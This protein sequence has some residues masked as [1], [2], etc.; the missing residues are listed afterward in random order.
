MKSYQYLI[1]GGGLAGG[2]AIDGIRK[3]DPEGTIA[4]VAR[5]PHAPYQRPP[6][7]KGYLTGGEGLDQVY[8][9]GSEYY[10]QNHVD[11]LTGT[12]A[13]HIDRAA[14]TVRLGNGEALGYKK[15]LIATGVT[16][17]RLP[18][19]GTELEW[20]W[21]LRTIEDSDSLRSAAGQGEPAVIL[22]GSF[23]GTEAA[24]ALSQLGMAV[25]MVFPEARLLARVCPPEL[26]EFIQKQCASRGIRLLAGRKPERLTGATQ[27][28][29]VLLD[30]GEA[31]PAS[32]VVMGVGVRLDTALAR[33]AGLEMD[34]SSGIVVDEQLRTSDPDIYAAGDVAAWPDPNS[35]KRIRVEHWDVARQQGLRAGRN[36][37]GEGKP[38]TAVPYFYSD[39]FGYSLE[40]WG[41]LARWEAMVQRGHAGDDNFS[42][43]SFKEGRLVGILAVN[44]SD[45]DRKTLP[46]L[47]RAK[48]DQAGIA[49]RL[50]DEAI[51][52]N[53]LLDSHSL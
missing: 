44:P 3:L 49:D 41:D 36:M 40:G 20:V 27:V 34:P 39:L 25:T 16:P 48:P 5:E 2:R 13:T 4:L 21:T 9:K 14:H 35:G 51:E 50:K 52:L 33:D 43:Y 30:D 38:Y 19:P 7:S 18:L 32:L 8:L 6:L 24:A 17:F 45:A 23:I 12:A 31:L 28:E 37:A 15:L 29:W 47:I 46:A 22:G 1:V 42:F 53:S 10:A 11:L 26:S